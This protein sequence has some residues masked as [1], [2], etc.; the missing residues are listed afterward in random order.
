MK[1]SLFSPSTFPPPLK[2]STPAPAPTLP[3]KAGRGLLVTINI[4]LKRPLDIQPQILGLH[5]RQLTQLSIHMRQMQQRD[6]L[7]QNLRQHIH[8]DLLL[9]RLAEFNVPLPEGLV[10][11]FEQHDLRE[12]LVGEGARHDEGGVARGAAE[13]DE[14]AF[15][16][17]DDVTAGGHEVAVDLGFDVGDGFAVFFD[18]G[19]VDF[20]VEMADI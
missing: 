19:D 10:L 12:H 20:D 2:T 8:A 6:L 13:V 5:L 1:P 11:G 7:V 3:G 18:P 14:A 15:G 4:R 9:A 17:E 16:E